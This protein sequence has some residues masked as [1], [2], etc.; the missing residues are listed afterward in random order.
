MKN[1]TE[2]LKENTDNKIIVY[3]SSNN[4]FNKFN[5]K[6]AP[7][8]IIWF[9]SNKEELLDNN[10]GAAG[11]KIIYTLEVSINKPAGWEEYEKYMLNTLEQLGYDGAI[12][13]DKNGEFDGFVFKP[14]QIKILKKEINYLAKK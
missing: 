14:N 1:F 8:K 10:K 6:Q 4:N 13:P 7:Q 12:L 3:H 9:T 2:W 5:L 11:N